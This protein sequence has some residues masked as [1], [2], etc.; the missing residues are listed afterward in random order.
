VCLILEEPARVALLEHGWFVAFVGDC[1]VLEGAS[2]ADATDVEQRLDARIFRLVKKHRKVR[3]KVGFSTDKGNYVAEIDVV[4]A[5]FSSVRKEMAESYV[6]MARS[7]SAEELLM[8]G[9]SGS[10]RIVTQARS[11][12]AKATELDG[13]PRGDSDLPTYYFKKPEPAPAVVAFY[14]GDARS[15]ATGFCQFCGRRVPRLRGYHQ[16]LAGAVLQ[17]HST[18]VSE[19]DLCQYGIHAWPFLDARRLQPITELEPAS[20]P[21]LL[22][23][24]AWLRRELE[25]VPP[26]F[27]GPLTRFLPELLKMYSEAP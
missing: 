5:R 7:C 26:E 12:L 17:L 9:E 13:V 23:R 11:L 10:A 1:F 18:R 24:A 20:P 8:L 21:P 16:G 2:E 14:P 19:T 25:L 3:L 27:G 15:A 6:R 4:G 22:S